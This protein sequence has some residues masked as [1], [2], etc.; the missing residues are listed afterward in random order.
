MTRVHIIC[1]G[2]TEAAFVQELLQPHF[3]S[4]SLFLMPSLIGK[5][6]GNVKFDRLRTDVRNRLLG[7]RG[8]YCTTFFD[9]YRLHSS[10]PGK[11]AAKAK[12]DPRDKAETVR[13][14]LVSKLKSEIDEA[15]MR[16]FI[17]YVQMYEFEALLFSDPA[18]FAKE[19]GKPELQSKLTEIRAEFATPEHINDHP[20]RVPGKRI[21]ALFQEYEK[22]IMGTLAALEI[23]LAKIRKECL[24]FD[25]WLK[26]LEAL[27]ARQ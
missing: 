6:G 20:H 3:S 7:D 14:E 25:A 26:R 15:P 24:L 5:A 19:I 9:F 27:S 10:F 22:P 2:Q 8:S 13:V 11:A 1:E 17:P 4:R 12:T 23:S 18:N 21:E 16:R